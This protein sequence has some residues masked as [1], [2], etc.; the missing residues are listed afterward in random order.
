MPIIKKIKE[1]KLP[2]SIDFLLTKNIKKL[3]EVYSIISEKRDIL[4][5]EYALKDELGEVVFAKDENGKVLNDQ[6]II[7]D[8]PSFNKDMISIEVIENEIEIT[9]LPAS[10]EVNITAKELMEVEWLFE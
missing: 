8:I 7:K 5:K 9:K 6:I 1:T 2:I 10:L 3:E 4:I